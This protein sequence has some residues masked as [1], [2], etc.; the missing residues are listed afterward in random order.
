MY[1][2]GYHF[3]SLGRFS[4]W[5]GKPIYIWPYIL[6]VAMLNEISW[7]EMAWMGISEHV[8]QIQQRIELVILWSFPRWK[9]PGVFSLSGRGA[10]HKNTPMSVIFPG[11]FSNLARPFNGLKSWKTGLIME[12]FKILVEGGRWR[13]RLHMLLGSFANIARIFTHLLTYDLRFGELK[14]IY[15]NR[16]AYML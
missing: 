2:L 9:G 10:G 4:K 3:Q 7:S 14:D 15:F 6:A 12:A 5:S 8:M 16:D 13:S 11:Y 1:L